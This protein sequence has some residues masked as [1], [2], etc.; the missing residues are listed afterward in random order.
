MDKSSREL[1]KLPFVRI[2]PAMTAGML[3]AYFGGSAV[4][5]V[6]LIIVCAAAFVVY[7]AVIK[8]R[9][10]GLML[11]AA[12]VTAGLISMGAYV[13]LYRNP[14]L[15]YSGKT[16]RAEF[17]VREITSLSGDSERITAA[18]SLDGIPAK[19][20]LSCESA[21]AVGQRAIADI[22]LGEYDE[23]RMLYNL[24]NG[25]L[26]SG[27]AENLE[28]LP[29]R[30]SGAVQM[31]NT[32]RNELIGGVE[33]VFFGEE[34][35]LVTALLFGEDS[36]LSQAAKERLRICGAAHFIAVSGS[37]FALFGA[38]I[39]MLIPKKKRLLKA[40]FP[41]V[42]APLAVIFFGTSAS[43]IR[44]A[45]MLFLGGAAM[46]FKR[47]G[48]PLNTLCAAFSLIAF[49][50]PSM[51]LDVGF[52]M[53]VLGVFGVAAVG[54]RLSDR[55]SDRLFTNDRFP[56]KAVP[57][58]K[59]SI[60]LLLTSISAVVCTAPVSV[61]VFKGVS[62]FGAVSSILLAM[63][64]TVSAP[65]A[66]AA[67]VTGSAVLAVPAAYL[68]RAANGFTE[69]FGSG[70]FRIIW[71]PLNFEG[72][73]I[74][75]ALAA[76][77]LVIIAYAP[78]K[79]I[80]PSAGCMAALMVFSV[81]ISL[82]TVDNRYEIRF[83]GNTQS[84]CAVIVNENTASVLISGSG[85]GLAGKL[86]QALR[87]HG[88]TKITRLTAYDADFTGALAIKELLELIEIEEIYSTPAAAAVLSERNVNIADPEDGILNIEGITVAAASVGDVDINADIV[89]YHGSFSKAPE[90][91]ARLA[92]FFSSFERELPENG[93][94]ALREEIVIKLNKK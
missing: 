6:I 35:S 92:V 58:L 38:V 40:L 37:H 94:N 34:R 55:I 74:L 84:G 93:V 88:V 11:C 25:I 31:I 7:A 50:S 53:S 36:K 24:A 62:L 54:V 80:A 64:I 5:T 19:I 22:E 87:E 23:V 32:L 4:Y 57:Y 83:L 43:V 52:I 78:A 39:T 45:M 30:S 73:W 21:L 8:K 72:A 47:K 79:T 71:L 70:K 18:V 68:L 26:L 67:A 1:W 12:G 10:T 77:M 28:I 65:F 29:G 41:L 61:A 14:V 3:L 15:E 2:A 66:V 44:A 48:D 85:S 56:K 63:L 27:S 33:R 75:A 60:T 81:G 59:A 17:E 16:L 89:V 91:P 20:N 86:S 69:L 42:F 13:Y 51:I 49:F 90:S 76:L 82:Y 46:L 9:R